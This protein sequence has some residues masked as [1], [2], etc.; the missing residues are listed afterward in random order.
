MSNQPKGP[1]VAEA[2]ASVDS[3][4][5]LESYFEVYERYF[6]PLRDHPVKMLEI[7]VD[8]GGSIAGWKKYFGEAELDY[9][10]FD[11][12]PD[13]NRFV[14][15]GVKIVIGDQMDAA[16]LAEVAR[17]G[18][19]DIVIDDGGHVTGQQIASLE[20]L[21]PAV[22]DGGYYVIEDTHTSFWPSYHSNFTI[23]STT[24]RG[25]FLDFAPALLRSQMEFWWSPDSGARSL[26]PREDRPSL[27][28]GTHAKEIYA[29]SFYDSLLV[30]E[31]S[32]RP[33][34]LNIVR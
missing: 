34:P 23:G 30:I 3:W 24:V 15:A 13:C 4:Q 19:Y 1:T 18:P 10:G 29:M 25:G 5:K 28:L 32:A 22:R 20:H 7:G 12:N 8:R 31:K 26:Q 21:F 14:R 6:A 2:F 11:I 17:A 9:T 16:L 33:E 27:D